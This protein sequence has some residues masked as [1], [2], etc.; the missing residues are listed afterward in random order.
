MGRVVKN[1]GYSVRETVGSKAKNYC[2]T[3]G[4]KTRSADAQ[5]CK[6]TQTGMH[7][8]IFAYLVGVGW[9]GGWNQGFLVS[10][11]TLQHLT[12]HD[13][14]AGPHSHLTGIAFPITGILLKDP[15]VKRKPGNLHP[16]RKAASVCTHVDMFAPMWETFLENF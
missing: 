15:V 1:I 7:T 4:H 11:V 5:I 6:H 16:S 2:Q 3:P 8:H 12:N 13:Q 14:N 9:G 10:P